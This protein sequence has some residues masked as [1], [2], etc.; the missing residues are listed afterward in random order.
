VNTD[1]LDNS[2][3]V[4]CSDHEVNIKILL[5]RLVRRGG[6]NHDDRDKLL[7]SMT[8]DVGELVLADNRAQN[9][10]LG[11]ARARAPEM[12]EVH[13][14]MV[15][16][17]V[18]R[19][20]LDRALELLPDVSGFAELGRAGRGL[21]SPELATLLAHVKLD[22][23]TAILDTE[24]PDLP[25]FADRLGGYFPAALT[26]QFGGVLGE[27]PL[28]REIVATV[29]VNE[30]V[31]AAGIEYAYRLVEELQVSPA[32]VVR[33][34]CV[35]AAV[36]D[37]LTFQASVAELGTTVSAQVADEMVLGSRRLLDRASRWLVTH[38]PRPL[39]VAEE[40]AHLGPVVATLLVGLQGLLR[41]AE[42][43]DAQER[44]QA[45]MAEG[46]PSELARHAGVQPHAVGLLDIVE[47]AGQPGRAR[48]PVEDVAELY[49]ALSERQGS[50]A[51]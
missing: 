10:T 30:L 16:D 47:V 4:D 44:T 33:A 21:S 42:A 36:F 48:L 27:H 13:E 24:V 19:R 26:D 8:D 40:T 2:A 6:L 3:G 51:G 9:A 12:V 5:D 50:T 1:A 38:R 37:L 18:E 15:A 45:L 17:L 22:L 11:L 46:V 23:K 29:L 49:F 41:G 32:D 28:R 14:R 34:F 35:S 43:V 39:A 7:R 25:A 20:G 31:D